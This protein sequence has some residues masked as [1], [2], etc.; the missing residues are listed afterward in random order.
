L[1]WSCVPKHAQ[2]KLEKGVLDLTSVDFSTNP[3]ILLQG[4]SLFYWKQWPL[5][6]K[7]NFAPNNLSATDTIV[8][9]YTM[10]TGTFETNRGFGT[11][12]FFIQQNISEK[13]HII[14][15]ERALAAVEVWINGKK[16]LSH[17]QI[18]KE[19]HNERIDGRPLAIPLPNEAQLDVMLVFSNYKHRLGGGFSINNTIQ[20]QPYF[21]QKN[22]FAAL[23]EGIITFL[24][25]LFG[26]Y[27]IIQYV[28]FPKFKYFLYLGLFCLIGASRQLF[29][30][31]GFIYNFFPEI[32]FEIVQKMRYIGYYG[33]LTAV[34]MYHSVLFPGYF[35]RRFTRV[36][37]F[38]PIIGI[39][40]VIVAPVYYGTF[41]A[42]FFQFYGM[43]VAM[44]SFYQ[45]INAVRHRKSYAVGMLVS[46]TITCIIFMNDLLNA[47]VIIKTEYLINYG[48]LVYLV[49]QMILNNKIQKQTA[50]K[51]QLLSQDI[52]KM[53]NRIEKKEQ[54]IKALRSETF[55]QLKSKEKLVE[56]LKKV[57]SKDESITIENVIANLK[58]ELL[59]DTQ[60]TRIKNDI[61]TLNQAFAERIKNVHPNLTE[62]DIEI[63]S[64]LRLSLDRKEIAK[65][66]FTSV[67][68]VRKSR[69]R[70]RKKMNLAPEDDLDAYV[71]GI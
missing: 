35:S 64:Y 16:V 6:A 54:E 48:I 29:V 37:A 14:R 15:I 33:S 58:S 57:A 62:T 60:L 43:L 11:Y 41:T 63:C 34:F 49:F 1:Q 38:I 19:A 52:E 51:M 31:E 27:Q 45:I 44:V 24:I 4:K 40:Y 12:R 26:A 69:Y 55:Q 25:L 28:N 17:G 8:W 2:P 46:L 36:F 30:G 21:S 22:K 61:E 67:E 53:A 68:A 59:E 5:D 70:L 9:P 23:T 7:G 65:L 32:S 10:S 39:L 13:T 50:K 3:E 56:N 42:P 66:R 47:M 71:K 20:Q 18:S